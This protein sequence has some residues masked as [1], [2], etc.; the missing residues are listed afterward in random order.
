MT[1]GSGTTTGGT[2]SAPEILEGPGRTE[3]SIIWLHGV[4]QGPQDMLAVAQRFALHEAG[5]RG[6]FPRAPA[7]LVS[8]V[9]GQPASAWFQPGFDTQW[10]ADQPSLHAAERWVHALI[11]AEV[12]RFGPRRVALA[13][14]SQGGTMALYSG[15]RYPLPLAGIAVYAAFRTDGMEFPD[16]PA[17]AAL[18]V[19]IW[20][21]H[22]ADDWVVPLFEGRELARSLGRQRHP[23]FFHLYQGGHEA[24]GGVSTEL[25]TFSE[26]LRDRATR[27]DGDYSIRPVRQPPGLSVARLWCFGRCG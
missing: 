27:C 5:V 20:M 3:L 13:G 16:P 22:G 26:R 10:R 21:G 14:F 24:F 23:V 9:T 1:A 15:L 4:G 7:R 19:P 12:K 11:D 25:A 17:T 6:V 18:K 8:A 2:V